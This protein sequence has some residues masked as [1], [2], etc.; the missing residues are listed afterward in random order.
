M[1]ALATTSDRLQA[2]RLAARMLRISPTAQACTTRL[3]GQHAQAH[4]CGGYGVGC[5]GNCCSGA[6][7]GYRRRRASRRGGGCGRRHDSA[8]AGGRSP[9]RD[10]DVRYARPGAASRAAAPGALDRRRPG[11]WGGDGDQ[12]LGRAAAGVLRVERWPCRAAAPARERTTV[13][14][15]ADRVSPRRPEPDLAGA[16]R[17]PMAF[18]AANIASG[19]S[20]SSTPRA[21]L[22]PT[23]LLGV[24][25]V[26]S[27]VLIVGLIVSVLWPEL[28]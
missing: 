18:V 5:P 6:W 11:R 26:V 2:R 4:E 8:H 3:R 23:V 22:L 24:G 10:D 12:D 9:V 7:A 21:A 16:H 1:R 19:R 15:R 14:C 28:R 25:P 27:I 17:L 13:G 20:T